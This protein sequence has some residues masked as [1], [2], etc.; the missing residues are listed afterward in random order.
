MAS[1]PF[2]RA[3]SNSLNRWGTTVRIRNYTETSGSVYDDDMS[4]AIS[5]TDY[6]ISG[7]VL[8]LDK[9]EGSNEANL[10]EQGKLINSDSKIYLNGSITLTGSVDQFKLQVGSP[11]GDWYSMIP[12][13][14]LNRQTNGTSVFQCS[15]I[16]LL[17]NGSLIGE[18]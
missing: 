4:L 3:F 12:L 11:T 5:G 9:T 18:T 13:G 17:T 7:V 8:S 14:T 16:R 15:Y 6:W 10:V 2:S 1:E